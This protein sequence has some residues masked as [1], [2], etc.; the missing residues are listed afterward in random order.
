[1]NDLST[2]MSERITNP[3][4]GDGCYR[5]RIQLE[6]QPGALSGSLEDDCHGFRVRIT[7]DDK[8]VTGVE[9]DT[10]RIP[11]SS[12]P[13]AIE[14]LQQLIGITL[15]TPTSEIV[16]RVPPRQ[17]CTHL[18]DLALLTMAHAGHESRLREYDITVSDMP[19][20]AGHSVAEIAL[21]GDKL[22][23]WELEWIHIAEP[24]ELAGRPVLNGFAAWANKTFSG[25]QQEAAFALSKGVFVALARMYDLSKIDGEP[26][27]HDEARLGVCYSYSKG[28][29]EGAV[30]LPD[31]VRD[32]SNTPEQLLK[33]L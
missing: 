27:L 1:M 12:C 18:Y 30:R 17:N 6:Q 19:R 25:L 9:A 14:P 23:R 5:R 8:V 29:V 4:Y 7:H 11:L 26:A 15:A 24:A 33:F 3:R 13:G 32:F 28:V 16:V 10:L 22:H 31:S 20:E 21:N 2:A